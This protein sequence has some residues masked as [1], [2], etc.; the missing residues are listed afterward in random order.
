M[1]DL[2]N[3]PDK[4]ATPNGVARESVGLSLESLPDSNANTLGSL[5]RQQKVNPDEFAKARQ[6]SRGTGL[7]LTT[8]QRNPQ[9]AQAL[10]SEPDWRSF[11][12]DSPKAG[13]ALANN[14]ELFNLAKDDTENAG[15]WEHNLD[16][17]KRKDQELAVQ[18]MPGKQ[19]DTVGAAFKRGVTALG[20]FG[21]ASAVKIDELLTA[22]GTMFLPEPQKGPMGLTPQGPVDASNRTAKSSLTDVAKAYSALPRDKRMEVAGKIF[23]QAYDNDNSVTGA[24]DAVN[25]IVRNWDGA[26]NFMVEMGVQA[27]PFAPVG[28][29]AGAAV[30]RGV[31]SRIASEKLATYVTGATT[32]AGQNFTS[33]Y[34]ATLSGEIAQKINEGMSFEDAW[35]YANTKAMTEGAVNAAFSFIPIPG[36]GRTLRSRILADM[37]KQ[38]V[39]GP[40]GAAAAAAA[41]GETASPA[42]LF[43]EAIGETFGAPGDVVL[44]SAIK[45]ARKLTS[46]AKKVRDSQEEF[47][48]LTRLVQLAAQSKLR[49]RAPD[50]FGQFVQQIADDTEGAVTEVWVD[51]R[52]LVDVLNQSGV[53]QG[54]FTAQVPGI[55]DQ[56]QDAITAG[57][58]VAIPVGE[59]TAHVVG[60]GLENSLL[61]HLRAREN[62]LS[63]VEAEQASQLAGEYLQKMAQD[64]V[65]QSADALAT[66]ASADAVKAKVLD[67]LNAGKRFTPDVN[68]G[69]ATLVRNFYTVLSSRYKI[70]PEQMWDGGWTDASGKVQPARRLTISVDGVSFMPAPKQSA[71]KG[72]VGSDTVNE[73]QAAVQGYE[74]MGGNDP[75]S[76][77]QRAEAED[78]LTPLVERANAAKPA[79]DALVSRIAQS[80]GMQ[81]MLAPVKGLKRAAEKLV[82]ETGGDVNLIRDM[83]RST[84]VV[85]NV[86]DVQAA[87]EQVRANFEIVR[88]KD[89]FSTPT[90][91]GYRDVLINVLT[92]DGMTAE[93]QINVPAMLAAKEEGH[94]LY[95]MARV[96]P[97]GDARR[98]QLEELQARLYAE[99]FDSA[100]SASNSAA[101]TGLPYENTLAESG[102]GLG[103]AALNATQDPSGNLATGTPSTSNNLAPGG[104]SNISLTSEPSIADAEVLN[105]AMRVRQGPALFSRIIDGLKLKKSEIATTVMEFMTGKGGEM[106]FLTPFTGGIPETV[107]F[108]DERRKALDTPK[109]D[110]TDEAD[111]AQLAKLMAAEALAA[112]SSAGNALTWYD[113]TIRQTLAM[114]AVKYPEL[115]TDAD[116]R[117]A[118]LLAT[119]IASQGMNVEDNLQFAEQQYEAYRRDGRFPEVGKGESAGAMVGNFKLANRLAADM[120]PELFRRFLTTSFTVG[121]LN[122]AGFEIGGELVDEQVLGSSVFGPKIG[123]GFYSNLNGNFEPVTMDMWFMRTIGRLSGTLP[124]YDPAKFAKQIE[125]FRSGLKEAGN[126]GVFADQFDATLVAQ[127]ATDEDAAIQLARQVKSAHEKDFKNNRDAYDAGTRVKSKMVAAAETMIQSL[128]KPRDVPA[129]G[130]ER[131]LLRDVVQRM[132]DIVEQQ[133]G[134]RIPPAALQ[135]LIWYPEQEL[136]KALGVKLRVTSQDYAGAARKILLKDGIDGN[137]LSAAAQSGTRHARQADGES[138]GTELRPDGQGANGTRP[139]EGAERQQFLDPRIQRT[140]ENRER[141]KFRGQQVIF[142]VAPDP[143]DLA[144]SSEWNRLS[145]QTRTEISE[146]VARAVLPE[147]LTALGIKGEIVLQTG[148]YLED[149]NP[150]FALKVAKGNALTA[151]KVMGH[152]LV[153]DSMVVL[154]AKPTEGTEETG[155]IQILIGDKSFEETEAIYKTLRA[156]KIGDEQPIGGQTT[157]NG[158]MTV[159]NFSGVKTRELAAAIDE[160]LGGAYAVE[161]GKAFTAFPSKEQYDY[162]DQ[163]TDTAGSGEQ[164]GRWARDLRGRA[165]EALRTE[166]DTARAGAAG[167]ASDP[168]AA[169]GASPR[170]GYHFSRSSRALL[171][172]R[173]HGTGLKGAERQRLAAATDARLRDRVYF[174]IDEGQGVTPESGVGGYA[175]EVELPNLYNAEVNAEG[176]WKANDLNA[177]ESAILD[178]GYA[179]YYVPS[180]SNGQGI[181]VVIG[182][183]SRN[184]I[185]RPTQ[186]PGSTFAPQ[187]AAAPQ[188]RRGLLARELS[189][190]DLPAVQAV[191]PSANTRG[192]VFSV[193]E[194]ELEAARDVLTRQGI[195]LPAKLNQ[196]LAEDMEGQAPFLEERA[197]AAGYDTVDEWAAN[198]IG[199]FM[200]AAEEWRQMNPAE[201][202]AQPKRGTF[203]PSQMR[204][205]LL[206]DADLSTFLHETGHFFLEV[207]ADLASQ[208][209][210]PA[211]VVNDM[212]AVL[213]WFGVADAQ[214]WASYTLE[215]KRPYHEKFAESFEQYLFEGKAPNA[216]LKP[217][218]RRFREYMTSVYKSFKDFMARYNTGLSDEVRGVFDRMIATEEQIKE[219]ERV[220]GML[221]DFDATNEAIEKLGARSLRDLKWVVNA[222]SKMLKQLQ[223]DVNEKRKAVKEEVTA[224]VRAMREYA[225]QRFLK[226]GELEGNKV[227]GGK[228]SLPVLKEMYG[229]G[230]AAPW[231]YLAT[232]MVTK[233]ADTGLHPNMVAELFGFTNGDEMT[234]AIIGAMPE[235]STID[236]LTDQRLLERY[237][238]LVTEKGI[239]RA[240]NEAIHNEARARFVATELKAMQEAMNPRERT[241]AGGSVNVLLRAA[242]DFAENLVSRR[243]VRDLKPGAHTAAEARAARRVTEAQSS[244]DTQGAITAQRDKLLNHYA[245]RMTTEA[246]AEIEK[247]IDYLRKFDKDSV[248][249]K[250]PPEYMAQIDKLLERVELRRGTSLRELDKRAKL[251]EWIAVQQELGLDPNI[252]DYLLEDVQL[253]SYKDMTVEEFRGLVDAVRNIEHLGRLK[254]KLLTLQDKRAFAAVVTELE[255]SIRDNATSSRPVRINA[256]T[257]VDKAT[258]AVRGFFSAHRKL[259]SMIRQFDGMKDGGVFWTVFNRT[260]NAAG[261]KEAVMRE[262]ATKALSK[263]FEPIIKG[264]KLKTM[265]FIPAINMSLSLET[266]LAI[267]LNWGNDANRQRVMDGDKWSSAQVEAILSTL[268]ADQLGFVQK[269]WDHINSYWPEIAAKEERVSGI[270][271]EKVQASAFTVTTADGTVVPMRGG[272]Y[273]IKYDPDRSGKADGQN[274]AE[275]TKQMMLGQMTRATTRRGHTKGRADTVNRAVRKDLGVIF[276]HVDQVIHDLAWHEWLIDATRILRAGPIED[277]IRE[278]AGPEVLREFKKALEDIAAGDV[279][280]QS[281]FEA[282]I[283]HL[284]VGTT[285][286][287]MGWNLMTSLMQPLGLTQSIVR[288]G[289]KWVGK[290]MARWVGDAVRMENTAKEVYAK[291]DFMRLRGETMQREINEIRNKVQGELAGPVKETYFYL[292]QKAQMIADMPTWLGQYEKAIAAGADE[293]GAIAQADQAVRDAQGGGQIMDLARVQRGGPLQ[294]L[295][296]NFYSYFSTTYN[297]TAE[298]FNAT[299]FKDPLQVG[300][301]MVDMLMLYTVP[302][303]L[304]FAMKEALKGG[305]DDDDLLEKLLREQLNYMLGTM[306]GLRELSASINGFYGYEGPAGTRFFSEVAKLGKQVEQ[307]EV[308][309]PLLKRL[310]NA[311]GILFHY[312][313]GQVNRAVEG[314]IA[315]SEGKT[316]NPMALLVGAPKE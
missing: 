155:L 86:S 41:V 193:N 247:K 305:G 288:I 167:R 248:R 108:L 39:A 94:K 198:D 102:Y 121:E 58:A 276:Q 240:A 173:L 196:T 293:A 88:I 174:Y 184:L 16:F 145:A 70:T 197:K 263:I 106:A 92:P 176:L 249:S 189:A 156:L 65:T 62:S 195:E 222:R 213:K 24:L 315:L 159:L 60:T 18:R 306:V 207:M 236:G 120:G 282:A 76:P 139:L 124:S 260:M 239:E 98:V 281:E 186:A 275:L 2:S 154:S 286:A 22:V 172:G 133:Y 171:D 279:P 214:T 37:P 265:E 215:Q 77:Q 118:F 6:L 273:P 147:T 74:Q 137:Q 298:R 316:A 36:E 178:A 129:S 48:Q 255:A 169:A 97:E 143:N 30:G 278:T 63:Q 107:A 46:D 61:P 199:G 152:G 117:N 158:V 9:Q 227:E 291:S 125:R 300:R 262:K 157:S 153:Q 134:E 144:L 67:Q 235:D 296:T 180:H 294:K 311:A 209:G 228:L 68:E 162:A 264:Q 160:A 268:T 231:R 128:D 43:L 100:M 47:E 89:R 95:E 212:N 308:D 165:Q 307:G 81:P 179:G 69:Y 241:A 53:E 192:G 5:Y 123:F 26:L 219:A 257:K 202:L 19:D 7:P 208:P 104:I 42:E 131:R 130:G 84:I 217:L 45:G 17:S 185:A 314:Y 256:P 25:Y 205:D 75:I 277:A 114:M 119:A 93:I 142:E 50:T 161:Y 79:F 274:A 23:E 244:G 290:G 59:F 211:D 55:A 73:V 201:A 4:S 266:R 115:N 113:D 271:P 85:P 56:L 31:A 220:A 221:P 206:K 163:G 182:N 194:S 203:S 13:A 299:S 295:F 218:F 51:A 226:F 190:L 309:A 87:I 3:L 245:A 1:L 289:P 223:K 20:V 111:R 187:P 246:L 259:S 285:I 312:P 242:K 254:D 8:A 280:A 177:T 251:A 252:P 101:S 40:T 82:L 122:A 210:A 15:S 10:L 164:A 267:A 138:V 287:G 57:E 261:D 64:I 238:D 35:E 49:E 14:V 44:S 149:T 66:E 99:A 105:Q 71:L 12:K 116:A 38:M 112:I 90:E 234:R 52:T 297:L 303:V 72:V 284:R 250:L 204:I 253:V 183:D 110:I 33:N 146:R 21:E 136:Y 272:Y 132:V 243:K 200:K 181:A 283:N 148:S 34:G 270:A 310:N 292:I 150:S 191:A 140:A 11:E 302:A 225:V 127:A 80:F 313:A 258:D 237:G 28:G 233:D 304:G 78:V 166:L 96:L 91:S 32:M 216:E 175:H 29:V 135:A 229:E 103:P 151:A 109:L 230:P 168:A 141:L 232:N 188:Y 83:L 27:A 170:L 224:E 54:A 269:A 301:F 126:N